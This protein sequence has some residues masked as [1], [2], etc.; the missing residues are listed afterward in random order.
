[1]ATIDKRGDGW[2]AQVRRR[3]AQP[4][5]KT[6]PTKAMAVEWAAR[7]EREHAQREA[8]GEAPASDMTLREAIEWY[9]EEV[10]ETAKWGRSK[11]A[12]LRRLASYEIAGEPLLTITTR[13][14]IRHGEVRN[15][16]GAG[17]PTVLN[18]FIWLRQ[19]L[20][21]VRASKDIK[22]DIALLEDAVHALRQRKILGKPTSRDRRITVD[23][24]K[25]LLAHFDRRDSTI[26]MGA[27]MRFALATARRQEEITRLRWA[28]LDEPTGTAWLDDVKH[29]TKKAGNRKQ[30]RMLKDA[31]AIINA[32][33]RQSDVV[34]PHK[35]STPFSRTVGLR[36]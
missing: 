21:S 28:D 19:V 10:G 34:F 25:R 5:S 20:K 6:F 35:G 9:E 27:I 29:P 17:A 33:A 2:R 18:D 14:Y 24:E 11:A 22:V 32:Q 3:G 13:D 30:F 7:I 4:K 12:D 15:K 23:E 16:M 26:P 31:W 8:R 36:E 1:M